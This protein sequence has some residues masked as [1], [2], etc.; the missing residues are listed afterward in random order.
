MAQ[1]ELRGEGVAEWADGLTVNEVATMKPLQ[2]RY[3][4]FTNPSGGCRDDVLFYRL[5]D[6]W[7]LV[8]NAGNAGKMWPYLSAAASDR[9][10]V[11]LTSRHGSRALIAVQGPRAAEILA[12]LCDLDPAALK[13]YF[14]A[15]GQVGGAP[16]VIARTGYTG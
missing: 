11:A 4:I 15:E 9:T 8:V 10:D 2:A 7:L 3:N 6:R 5:P 16:A 12:P 14:C 13:Y 1:Y